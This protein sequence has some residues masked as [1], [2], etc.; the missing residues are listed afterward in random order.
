[1][2]KY[3][4]TENY[5][6]FVI[7]CPYVLAP[8]PITHLRYC[9]RLDRN[10]TTFIPRNS[11]EIFDG[12]AI[13]IEEIGIE[14]G[15]DGMG[16]GTARTSLLLEDS[17]LSYIALYLECY[18]RLLSMSPQVVPGSLDFLEL[19]IFPAQLQ[20]HPV[21][22]SGRARALRPR[23]AQPL[24]TALAPTGEPQSDVVRPAAASGA[25]GQARAGRG[26]PRGLATRG[27]AGTH[28]AP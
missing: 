9:L 7:S 25:R 2:F 15:I 10:A 12:M 1:M 5:K 14:I 8:Q 23:R 13:G 11:S 20:R 6:V 17:G 26:A 4:F 16:I 22:E 19:T 18:F 24:D 3:I 27:R 28:R 21:P